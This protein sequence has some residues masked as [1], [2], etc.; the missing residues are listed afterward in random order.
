M[1]G[2][3]ADRIISE[4]AGDQAARPLQ[5]FIVAR[6]RFAED[7]LGAAVRGGVRQAV[8]LGSGL[9]TMSLRQP[10]SDVGLRMYE[11]DHPAT[12]RWKRSRM[13]EAGLMAP[14]SL[15]FVAVDFEKDDLRSKLAMA[16][17]RSIVPT[18]FTWLG[19]VPYLQR[20]AVLK[21]LEFI[22]SIPNSEVVFDYAEPLENCSDLARVRLLDMAQRTAAIGEPWLTFF[23]PPE[24]AK[25]LRDLGFTRQEDLGL[26]QIDVRY[27][28]AKFEAV[29]A[30]PGPHV[31]HAVLG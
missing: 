2:A 18:F 12:Q 1:L 22:A 26:A 9:D 23:D 4:L 13:A 29:K 24:V 10:H 28:G 19:V 31:L 8:V 25:L 3:D 7:C 14:T 20:E 15:T 30:R 16:G 11:V 21:T 5:L 17:F 27:Q 6:S